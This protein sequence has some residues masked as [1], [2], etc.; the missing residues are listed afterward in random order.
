MTAIEIFSNSIYYKYRARIYSLSSL[1]VL[2]LV[3][4]SII[5]PFF[6]MFNT[7]GFWIKTK[8]HAETPD[9][10]FQYKYLLLME[11]GIEMAPIVCSTFTSYKENNISDDCLIIKVQEIDTNNDGK[12]D[13][14][15]FEAQFYTDSPI[16]NIR[17]FLFFDFKL[18]Q[19]FESSIQSLAIF[20]HTLHQDEQKIYFIADLE[21]KQRGILH[22][23][24]LYEAYNH[25]IELS[26]RTLLQLLSQSVNKKF[27]A[28]ITNS[29]VITQ[30]GFSKEDMITIQGELHYKDHLIYYQPNLWEELKWAWIHERG[31]LNG[32]I[33]GSLGVSFGTKQHYRLCQPFQTFIHISTRRPTLFNEG[34]DCA[35]PRMSLVCSIR[36]YVYT[37]GE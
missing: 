7:G 26:D 13:I 4:M 6:L 18:K 20:D 17:F 16:K 28:E 3:M 34:G 36:K 31:A 11:R 23:D 29:H 2:L 15:K 25:S 37:V 12:K 9:I 24:H 33:L 22:S 35:V 21:L 32:S 5:T 27:S 14:L 1:I 10:S 8:T 30:S 19:I